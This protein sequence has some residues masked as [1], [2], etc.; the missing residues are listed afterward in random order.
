MR[1]FA[2]TEVLCESPPGTG[3]GA[4]VSQEASNSPA[5]SESFEPSKRSLEKPVASSEPEFCARPEIRTIGSLSS[6]A[7]ALLP[8]REGSAMLIPHDALAIA[9]DNRNNTL[10]LF[11][12]PSQTVKE[13]QEFVFANACT[14]NF[15][16]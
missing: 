10:N 6:K 13:F 3:T 14:A 9:A 8:G 11:I 5:T 1:P 15:C 7:R 2:A 12:C 16:L 4:L